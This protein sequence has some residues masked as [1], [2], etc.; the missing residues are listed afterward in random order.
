MVAPQLPQHPPQLLHRRPVDD[1][2][3]TLNT[4]QKTGLKKLGMIIWISIAKK[5]G[6]TAWIK[7][8]KQKNG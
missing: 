1:K 7:L 2:I 6:P 5:G 4:K 8:Y 3:I